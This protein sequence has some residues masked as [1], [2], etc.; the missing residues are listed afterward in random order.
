MD[1]NTYQSKALTTAI[2]HDSPNEIFHLALGLA[3]ETGEV[4]EKLKKAVRDNNAIITDETTDS[5]K[6][7]LGDVLWYIAVLSDYLG[8]DLQDIAESNLKKLQ[9]RQKR[10]VLGGSGDSR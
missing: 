9:D 7:E 2:N 6:K 8:V 5:I 4:M 1:F 10:G 3:G